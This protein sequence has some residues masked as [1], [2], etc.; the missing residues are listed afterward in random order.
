M[1]RDEANKLF[2]VFLLP[3][4]QDLDR[5]NKLFQH[6]T[7]SSI[8][9]VQDLISLYTSVVSRIC[10]PHTFRTW[11]NIQEYDVEDPR[12][13][14]PTMA[15][16]FGT[17]FYLELDKMSMSQD[18]L[19]DVK[20]K[21]RNYMLELAIQLKKRLPENAHI[22]E[23]LTSFSPSVVLGTVRPTLQQLSFLPLFSG[24][25]GLLDRQWDRICTVHW[26]V[27]D[28]NQAEKFW[29]E[30]LNYTDAADEHVFSELAVFALSLMSLPFSNA[31]VER[32]FSEMNLIKTRVR[33]RMKLPL[34]SAIMH[35]RGYFAR[36]DKNCDDFVPT[37]DMLTFNT[38]MY[39]LNVRREVDVDD[40]IPDEY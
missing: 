22:L 39:A 34:L 6:N 2:L 18:K 40:V 1:Y 3:W 21:C 33:N 9:L 30:V 10:R 14:L 35:V 27:T 11:A 29:N 23:S 38:D 37:P 17:N 26:K 28:D 7:A 36:H 15:I 32:S 20:Q 24:N 12:N 4:L 8:K 19:K 13:Q 31:A 16:N 25:L 5:V